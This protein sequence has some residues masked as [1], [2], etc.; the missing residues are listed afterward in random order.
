MSAVTIPNE[1]FVGGLRTG[2]MDQCPPNCTR[3][4]SMSPH[5]DAKHTMCRGPRER[6]PRMGRFP[7]MPD[8]E[9]VSP[10]SSTSRVPADPVPGSRRLFERAR[11]V[12]PGGVSSPVRA[13]NAVGGS[14]RFIHSA[15]GAWLTDVDGREYVDLVGSWGP[16][17][18]GPRP[19]RGAG[20]GRRRGGTRHLLRHPHRA[21]GRAGRGDRGAHPGRAGAVRVV[22]HRG[23]DVGDPAGPRLHRPRPRGEVRRLLPRSRRRPARLGRVRRR[24]ARDPGHARRAG[25]RGGA[26]DRAAVPRPR[27]GRGRLRRARRPHRLPHHRGRPRQHGRD[28]ARAGLQR[29]PRRDLH[30]PRRAVRQRRGDDRLPRLPPGPVGS[31]RQ[32]RGLGART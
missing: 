6:G 10:V 2:G 29:L 7:A 17:L 1:V 31:R 27:R 24:H 12:I 15:R 14:P 30:P 3:T 18:L 19:P 16:M 11:Q 32:A 20:R 5:C 8:N 26:H 23:H 13:F 9:G 4:H 21:R 28:R 22:R 25:V